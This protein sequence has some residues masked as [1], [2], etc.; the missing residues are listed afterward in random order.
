MSPF[1]NTK[2]QFNAVRRAIELCLGLHAA[3]G[4]SACNIHLAESLQSRSDFCP[5]EQI[6]IAKMKLVTDGCRRDVQRVI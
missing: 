4:V 5:V 1:G 6:S 3:T 2:R